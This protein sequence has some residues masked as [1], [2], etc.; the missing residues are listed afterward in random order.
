MRDS[1]A[2][3]SRSDGSRSPLGGRDRVGTAV[4]GWTL[5]GVLGQG[6]AGTVYAAHNASGA[7]AAI[8][9]PELKI[10][11]A[12]TIPSQ[13]MRREAALAARLR[14]PNI[15][16]VLGT[17]TFDDGTPY[18]ALE[19]VHGPPLEQ[20]ADSL[21]AA[22]ID[23]IATQLFAALSYAHDAGVVH[24]DV[25]PNNILLDGHLLD[26]HTP[27]V[28]GQLKLTDFGLSTARHARG[29]L[30]SR[31]LVAG[32]PG[33]LSPEQALGASGAGPRSDLYG[34][35]AV[36]YRLIAGFPPHFGENTTEVIRR[37]LEMPAIALRPRPGLEISARCCAVVDT[38]LDRD[39]EARYSCAA[40][41]ARAWSRGWSAAPHGVAQA[42]LVS[43]TRATTTLVATRVGPTQASQPPSR[44]SRRQTQEGVATNPR[45]PYALHAESLVGRDEVLK[46]LAQPAPTITALRGAPGSGKSVV[47]DELAR[48][49]AAKG[50]IVARV[51]G[52]RH[53]MGIPMEVAATLAV[54]LLGCAHLPVPRAA[55]RLR[56]HLDSQEF[57]G[58]QSWDRCFSAG[59]DALVDALLGSPR[60]TDI[61]GAW[62]EATAI[63]RELVG[64]RPALL[65]VDDADH[66]DEASARVVSALSQST[67]SSNA[68]LG[69]NVHVVVGANL[70]TVL[71]FETSDVI[72]PALPSGA[73]TQLAALA[74][75]ADAGEP[76]EDRELVALARC[77][78]DLR[79]MSLGDSRAEGI[80]ALWAELP[81]AAQSLVRAAAIFDGDAPDRGL[82]FVAASLGVAITDADFYRL[83]DDGW[84]QAVPHRVGSME[85]WVRISSPALA[86]HVRGQLSASEEQTLA[87]AAASWLAREC[88]DQSPGVYA[89]ISRFAE[90]AGAQAAAAFA[91][92]EAGRRASLAD[93]HAT[94][95]LLERSLRLAK[96]SEDAIDRP[97]VCAL[98]AQQYYD[99]GDAAKAFEYADK[100]VVEEERRVLRARLTRLQARVCSDERK[101]AEAKRLFEA[102][103]QTLG[104]YP[105][106]I[107]LA[108][109][110]A[111]H[112]W[113]VGYLEGKTEEGLALAEKALAVAGTID[114]PAFRA[115]LCGR[116]AAAQ[117][118]AGDWDGQLRTNWNDLGL[119]LRARNTHGVMRA[120]INIGVCYTNRG[121]LGLARAHTEEAVALATSLNAQSSL[122]VALNNLAMI[123]F[124]DGRVE[125]AAKFALAAQDNAKARG[126][127]AHAE[128]FATLARIA[129][130]RGE[131]DQCAKRVAEMLRVSAPAERP[132]AVRTAGLFEPVDEARRA[133]EQVLSEGIADP[134]ERAS[135]ELAWSGLI[136]NAEAKR[137][138]EAALLK[139][140][141]D[142]DVE[143]RRWVRAPQ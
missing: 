137:S 41:A 66:I 123:A 121:L 40:R 127:T 101:I 8:K 139:L 56:L 91:A 4:D 73:L 13:W 76:V 48:R 34:A 94:L 89:L 45:P 104:P 2:K 130:H 109:A 103:K 44:K 53:P 84:L 14:H 60:P 24:G 71:P 7:A 77:P 124:D 58:P 134:Y 63:L 9:V 72:L 98:L 133:L 68:G 110:H 140:G 38:L 50:A 112:A 138:A 28:L 100:T 61:G 62:V 6:G 30:L 12:S 111:G 74:R 136:G 69:N 16:G 118:R 46:Q 79:L 90:E 131:A 92:A 132:L 52:R 19:R 119:S 20:I 114:A 47:L 25:S 116:V 49:R 43:P 120:H 126:S 78:A 108:S 87:L 57:L 80:A 81:P 22:A 1:S 82:G 105:D 10:S 142:L 29:E 96:G 107:E 88:F 67:A 39:R 23:A 51:T 102:A 70:E 54:Q 117:L 37:T 42:A 93:H 135:T 5:T 128:T 113:V 65:V 17:G 85:Y 33:Y 122:G 64:E 115:S 143:R 125:D 95:G 31:V 83:E 36:L 97:A 129:A 21:D 27:S 35:G 55:A 86:S 11:E 106:P 59:R 99:R 32:T 3:P 18:V 15:V 26:G 141:A 75:G